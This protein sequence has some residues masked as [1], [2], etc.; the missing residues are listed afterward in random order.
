MKSKKKKIIKIAITL[1]VI[2]A[3]ALGG[4]FILKALGFTDPDEFAKLKE[5]LG[6]SIVFWLIIAA[7]QIFQVIFVPISNQI[8]T[9]PLALLFKDE[10]W[11][12]F[13]TS[14][15]SIWVA[16]M[17]LYFIGRFGGQKILKWILEDEEQVQRCT[18]FMNKGW[19][20]YPIGM[21][22]PLPDDIVTVLSGTAKFNVVFVCVC[23]LFTRAVDISISVWGWG[24]LT[25]YWWGWIILGVGVVLLGVLTYLFF[26][27]QKIKEKR[28]IEEENAKKCPYYI[29][30]DPNIDPEHIPS[31][32]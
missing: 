25:Q 21:L 31:C 5:Q 19:I 10:L 15:L 6:D 30:V 16:T 23:S 7:L 20:F 11:K 4:Y 2:V 8:I 18:N 3:I 13:L 9:I 29:D 1:L 28:K 22:L 26:R 24:L 17:I 27:W 14:W 32:K 12:V